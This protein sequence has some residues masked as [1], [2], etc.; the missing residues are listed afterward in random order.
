MNYVVHVTGTIM[1]GI[2]N[3]PSNSTSM[4]SQHPTLVGSC[5][6]H[7]ISRTSSNTF[8]FNVG[9]HFKWLFWVSYILKGQIAFEGHWRLQCWTLTPSQGC[10]CGPSLQLPRDPFLLPPE[11]HAFLPPRLIIESPGLRQ[12]SGPPVTVP[13]YCS[14]LPF[15]F[16]S[17]HYYSSHI[18]IVASS[19]FTIFVNL[20]LSLVSN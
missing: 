18:V 7:N 2:M 6:G 3:Q 20:R 14:S 1:W 13:L 12:L 15:P 16:P 5:A 10:V 17:L 11:A 9:L 19:H 8:I 4:Y